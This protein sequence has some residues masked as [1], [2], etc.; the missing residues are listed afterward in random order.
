MQPYANVVSRRNRKLRDGIIRYTLTGVSVYEISSTCIDRLLSFLRL[1]DSPLDLSHVCDWCADFKILARLCRIHTAHCTNISAW[2]ITRF[3]LH[4]RN[5]PSW[6]WRGHARPGTYER[7]FRFQRRDRGEDPGGVG[8][9]QA[10]VARSSC[11]IR[12]FFPPLARAELARVHASADTHAPARAYARDTS[13]KR[14]R[15]TWRTIA[16]ARIVRIVH[17]VR[18]LISFPMHDR[19]FASCRH[20]F[21]ELSARVGFYGWNKF[22]SL[23]ACARE[24]KSPRAN[25]PS[26]PRHRQLS[27]LST[28]EKI[29][30]KIRDDTSG[31]L[32]QEY[33]FTII[34]VRY[35][36]WIWNEQRRG[37]SFADC[38]PLSWN[39][40]AVTCHPLR[41]FSTFRLIAEC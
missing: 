35:I 7:T 15:N 39:F 31:S 27:F 30:R 19:V 33:A 18:S 23:R 16:E 26:P 3:D 1:F 36:R 5:V 32:S 29:P 4:E 28:S 40:L 25:S 11:L 12:A 21:P 2:I 10:A 38:D 37:D 20:T 24:E 13:A 34:C 41:V 14:D 17:P 22:R 9:F 8:E 6:N